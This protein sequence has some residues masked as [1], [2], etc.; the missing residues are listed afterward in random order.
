MKYLEKIGRFIKSREVFLVSTSLLLV[1][2]GCGPS[3]SSPE[4]VAKF[5]KAGPIPSVID[6]DRLAKGKSGPYRVAPGDVL[7]FQ[8][9]VDLR[10]VSSD[11]AEWLRPAYGHKDIEP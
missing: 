9:H 3:I 1:L 5:E 10:V 6:F 2:C 11:L 4:Q 7:E 8:M